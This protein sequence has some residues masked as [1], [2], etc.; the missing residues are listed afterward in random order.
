ME[1]QLQE[2]SENKHLETN[3]HLAELSEIKKLL[4]DMNSA[5]S[6]LS[7]HDAKPSTLREIEPNFSPR[8]MSESGSDSE[9][10]GTKEE[11][12]TPVGSFPTSPR[13]LAKSA[14][15]AHA[16]EKKKLSKGMK[17]DDFNNFVAL[18]SS[19]FLN[20]AVQNSN[21]LLWNLPLGHKS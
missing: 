15:S 2:F 18:G 20:V 4:Q 19:V 3:S 8:K 5:I 13:E 9:N 1:M 6:S 17:S 14:N 16:Q 21:T 10:E 11:S 7:N 12:P